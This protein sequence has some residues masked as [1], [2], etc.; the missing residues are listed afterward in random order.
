MILRREREEPERVYDGGSRGRS[1]EEKM[2]VCLLEFSA[3]V[4]QLDR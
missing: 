3:Q 1:E 4:W 2:R